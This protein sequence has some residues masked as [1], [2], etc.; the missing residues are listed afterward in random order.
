MDNSEKKEC[1]TYVLVRH[2]YTMYM[3]CSDTNTEVCNTS[4][5]V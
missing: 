4:L 1:S 3:Y 5:L 2:F